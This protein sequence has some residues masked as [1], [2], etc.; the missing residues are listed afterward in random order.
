MYQLKFNNKNSLSCSSITDIQSTEGNKIVFTFQADYMD[1]RT[2]FTDKYALATIEVYEDEALVRIIAGY[3][4]L[5]SLTI[6][7][8]TNGEDTIQV[9]VLEGDIADKV[10]ALEEKTKQLDKQ[11]NPQLTIDA[12]ELDEFK[13]YRQEENKKALATFLQ[14]HPILY[15][16]GK[17]YGVTEEDQNELSLNFMQ[18]ELA[19]KAGLDATL[20]WHA[21]HEKCTTWT[22]EELTA[23]SLQIK[24]FVYPY[25]RKMQD[26]KEEIYSCTSKE[27]LLDIM[28]AYELMDESPV[29]EEDESETEK[30]TNEDTNTSADKA[31]S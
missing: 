9:T 30:D 6:S 2:L 23:L 26:I 19:V 14:E 3:T 10:T 22:V 27:E 12:M 20:E 28:I 24:T 17:Y 7:P 13:V 29:T 16:D 18:Y 11:L 21:V 31:N 8:N 1:V 25:L 4:R 5:D 15:I